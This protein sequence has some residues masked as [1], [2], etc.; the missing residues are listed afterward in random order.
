L[1]CPSCNF[2]NP[3]QFKFCGECGTRIIDFLPGKDPDSN[4]EEFS[5]VTPVEVHAIQA[6][7]RHITVMFCDLVGSTRLSE[8]LDPEDFRQI[9]HVYQDTCVYVVNQYQGHLAQYLGDGVLIYF[10]FYQNMLGVALAYDLQKAITQ[11]SVPAFKREIGFAENNLSIL[12]GRNPREIVSPKT[13]I[14]YEIP[15]SIPHGIPSELL[16]RRPDVIEAAQLYRAQNARIGVAQAARF[17]AISLTGFVGVGSN[18][19]SA[20]LDN[21]LGWS[22]GASLLGPL[23]EWGKNVRRVEFYGEFSRCRLEL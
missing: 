6:E 23:F 20:L 17:P 5:Y 15:D 9:L 2:N 19:L 12:L 3:D 16:A 10:G 1:K 11:V 4:K 8:Q 7:R 22:V 14:D 21:G 13:L 18:D